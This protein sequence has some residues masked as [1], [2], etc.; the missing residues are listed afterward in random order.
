MHFFSYN[1]RNYFARV[2]KL[3]DM[4]IYNELS[5]IEQDKLLYKLTSKGEYSSLYFSCFNQSFDL[6]DYIE[7]LKKLKK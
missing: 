1:K 3:E 2:I 5:L 6:D 4:T 7:K